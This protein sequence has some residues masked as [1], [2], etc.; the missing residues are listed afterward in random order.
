MG[1]EKRKVSR[2]LETEKCDILAGLCHPGWPLNGTVHIKRRI[3]TVHLDMGFKP[4][5]DIQAAT[6]SLLEI[7]EV[8][9]PVHGTYGGEE[10]CRNF[11]P[12]V[13]FPHFLLY[14][15]QLF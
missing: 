9:I 14:F 15:R 10:Q 3:V 4:T 2:I 11:L 6:Q 1:R 12:S 13:C 5:E 8:T 7:A